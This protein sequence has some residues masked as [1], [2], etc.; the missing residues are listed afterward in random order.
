VLHAYVTKEYSECLYTKHIKHLHS[1]PTNQSAFEQSSSQPSESFMRLYQCNRTSRDSNSSY[2]FS[3]PWKQD[4]P[5]LPTNLSVCKHQTRT[6]VRRLGRQQEL[7]Q[8]Y[9]TVMFEQ[10]QRNFIEKVTNQMYR[11]REHITYHTIQCI[12]IP[13]PPH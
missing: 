5:I 10:E 11:T 6:L 7:F 13:Q 8:L 2:I 1:S 9:N 4:H 12:R 3:F